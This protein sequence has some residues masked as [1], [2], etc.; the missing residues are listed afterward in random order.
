M[1]TNTPIGRRAQA[2]LAMKILERQPAPAPGL[3]GLVWVRFEA[4]ADNGHVLASITSQI[5]GPAY[6]YQRVLLDCDDIAL[7]TSERP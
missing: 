7:V 2:R 3:Y 6:A 5:R 1:I 4:E